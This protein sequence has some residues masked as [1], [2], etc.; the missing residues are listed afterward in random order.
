M[1]T[2]H[3]MTR[4]ICTIIK[5]RMK[6]YSMKLRYTRK[7]QNSRQILIEAKLSTQTPKRSKKEKKISKFCS[8]LHAIQ[9]KTKQKDSGN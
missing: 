2:L 8:S 4:R 6:K 7:G 9:N 3:I 5:H 1:E